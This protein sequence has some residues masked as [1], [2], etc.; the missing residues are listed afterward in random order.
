MQQWVINILIVVS[1]ALI[2]IELVIMI[3]EL[4]IKRSKR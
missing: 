3:S 1:L 4:P 2:G